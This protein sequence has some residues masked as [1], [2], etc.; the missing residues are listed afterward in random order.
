MS[1]KKREILGNALA[2]IQDDG[3]AA[4][5]MRHLASVSAMKLGSLQY[6]FKTREVLLEALAEHI[7]DQYASLWS[8]DNTA[9]ESVSLRTFIEFLLDDIGRVESAR[10]WPQLWAW[11]LVEPTMKAMMDKL[12]QPLVA[13][14]NHR[15]TQLGCD[16]PKE[17]ALAMLCLLEGAAIF[18]GAGS[19]HADSRVA[20]RKNLLDT[21]E[22]RF[23]EDFCR[24]GV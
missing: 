19:F 24:A 5:T 9:F 12:Y 14:L 11:A 10:L 7:H 17:E 16:K 1:D 22:A 3:Y 20:M 15:F 4:L 18:V 13:F 8:Q 6:H 23:G 2:I 21:F